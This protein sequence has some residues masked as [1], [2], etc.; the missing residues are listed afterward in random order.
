[1]SHHFIISFPN[2]LIGG[3][4][5]GIQWF[6]HRKRNCQQKQNSG[7]RKGGHAFEMGK[8]QAFSKVAV[9]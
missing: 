4:A 3:G 1:M 7:V 5:R 2:F 6:I 9:G 8:F